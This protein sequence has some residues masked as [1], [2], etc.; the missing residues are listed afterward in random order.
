MCSMLPHAIWYLVCIQYCV[1]RR[2]TPCMCVCVFSGAIIMWIGIFHIHSTALIRDHLHPYV[3]LHTLHP[4]NRI[5]NEETEKQFFSAWIETNIVCSCWGWE[6]PPSN[7]SGVGIAQ[8]LVC[9]TCNQKDL[10]LSPH[11]SSRRIFFYMVSFLC[12]LYFGIFSTPT[13]PQLHVKYPG[14]YAKSAGGRFKLNSCTLPRAPRL[15]MKWHFKLVHGCVVY[16]QCAPRQQ[17]FYMP[18]AMQPPNS[19]TT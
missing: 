12:W 18:L 4:W 7:V 15:W 9:R 11:R 1:N 13:L 8:W 5:N 14:Q 16:T 6:D 10:G 19:T 3:C 2:L 17:Q